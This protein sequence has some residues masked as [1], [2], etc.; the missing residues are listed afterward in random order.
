MFRS[1]VRVDAARLHLLYQSL[2]SISCHPL[3]LAQRAGEGPILDNSGFTRLD[4][5]HCNYIRS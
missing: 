2:Y 5:S 4:S 3:I 1:L